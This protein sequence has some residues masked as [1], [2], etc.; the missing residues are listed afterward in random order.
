MKSGSQPIAPAKILGR[1][2]SLNRTNS[3]ELHNA[4]SYVKTQILGN[5]TRVYFPPYLL[6]Y[7]LTYCS[8]CV[9]CI[10]LLYTL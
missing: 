4:A 9:W 7:L 3:T 10:K 6:T 1:V 8:R 5:V 2:A